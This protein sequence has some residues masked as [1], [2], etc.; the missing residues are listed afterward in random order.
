MPQT[1]FVLL[2]V[3][4]LGRDA[5]SCSPC[6]ALAY[7]AWLACCDGLQFTVVPQQSNRN[8]SQPT[9]MRMHEW[10][11]MGI[12]L[13]WNACMRFCLYCA[14][15]STHAETNCDQTPTPKIWP[16]MSQYFSIILNFFIFMVPAPNCHITNKKMQKKKKTN[17]HTHILVDKERVQRHTPQSKRDETSTTIWV[18]PR[19][20]EHGPTDRMDGAKQENQGKKKKNIQ[21]NHRKR[22]MHIYRPYVLRTHARMRT[23]ARLLTPFTTKPVSI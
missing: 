17:T 22:K 12:T 8:L 19:C 20:E 18:R 3:H 23:R 2:S 1:R 11:Q 21:R 16:D 5:A 10:G 4:Q 7:G 6:V 13:A 14:S 9:H 15:I